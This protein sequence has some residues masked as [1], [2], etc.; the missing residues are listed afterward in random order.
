M[1]R[2]STAEVS[3]LKVHTGVARHAR[4]DAVQGLDTYAVLQLIQADDISIETGQCRKELI[5][6]AGELSCLVTIPAAAFHVIRRTTFVIQWI[7]S[8]VICGNEEVEGVHRCHPE[9]AAHWLW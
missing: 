5:T 6:L 3:S 1:K 8:R 7:A 9:S 4:H 2:G